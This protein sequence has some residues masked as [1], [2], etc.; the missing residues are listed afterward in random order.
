MRRRL[1]ALVIGLGIALP[2]AVDLAG[3][4]G[5][6][7]AASL[8]AVLDANAD[9][10]PEQMAS[11]LQAFQSTAPEQEKAEAAYVL[12]RMLQKGTTYDAKSS[13]PKVNG[14]DK[15]TEAIRL[16]D[17]ASSIPSL[18]E[19][20]A[21]HIAEVAGVIGDEERGRAALDYLKRKSTD[22]HKKAMAEY[23]LGQ[24]YMR[25]KEYDK[26][27][28]SFDAIRKNY[29]D[30]EFAKATNYYLAEIILANPQPTA[31]DVA[32]AVELYRTYLKVSPDG[33]FT[34]DAIARLLAFA[35]AGSIQLTAADHD[36][37]ALAYFDAQHYGLALEQWAQGKPDSQPIK[38]CICMAATGK[39]DAATQLLLQTIKANPTVSYEATA[40]MIANSL[41]REDTKKLWQQIAN[42]HPAKMDDPY[43]NIAL[44]SK[45]EEAVPIWKA[46]VAKYPTS[47]FA[48][49][50]LWWIFW[51]AYKDAHGDP[52]KLQSA[53]TYAKLCVEKYPT[54]KAA[55]KLGFWEGKV[56]EQLHKP[57]L[58]HAAY[59]FS[60]KNFPSYYYGHRAKARLRALEPK[61]PTAVADPATDS[62][63]TTKPTRISPDI[64]WQW[65]TPH[66]I[67]EPAQISKLYGATF[68]ELLK[69]HQ[70]DECL[71][72]LPS[73]ANSMLKSAIL[74]KMH[75]NLPAIGAATKDLEGSPH[76]NHRWLTSYPLEYANWI[77][78][79]AKANSVDPLLVHALIRE[80]SRYNADAI[81]RSKAIG[82]MQLMPFTAL[83][84]AKRLGSPLSSPNEA[85]APQTNIKLGTNYLAY[86]IKRFNGN[87]LL[88]VASYNGGPNAV[89]T[90]FN[91]HKLSGS[92]D[93]DVF[94]ENIPFRETRDYVRKVFGSYWTYE[95]IYARKKI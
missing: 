41:N 24:S 89:T 22:A 35:K 76:V 78:D 73:D 27:K 5:K 62:G 37:I 38:R 2:A 16:Y 20:S 74:A 92:S 51:N 33:R 68:S 23:Q 29:P 17:E 19:R 70:Y 49:E 85:F 80:E 57:A 25:T 39:I 64:K 40:A 60:A 45:A 9:A 7:G 18:A 52:A 55:A 53:L 65:P 59:E 4:G 48:P 43:W 71:E 91:Q 21:W 42:A 15:L 75:R 79:N 94:V 47:E 56:E 86:T 14:T 66:E 87:E 6:A 36:G 93:F 30:S 26:A 1:A 63:W 72:L 12:A 88:A 54:T 11:Q 8:T 61:P 46:L 3:I 84:V 77:A 44:R 95:E 81:S 32:N 67:V 34:G 31:D 90:W 58:A 50:S 28:N 83:G 10:P 69:L 13:D 82:L